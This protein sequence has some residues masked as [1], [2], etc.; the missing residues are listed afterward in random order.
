MSTD[1]TA[2][3]FPLPY[4]RAG[5]DLND[6]SVW[7]WDFGLR[8]EIAINSLMHSAYDWAEL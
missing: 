7:F 8:L 5:L 3:T 6:R 2:N 1:S 4:I